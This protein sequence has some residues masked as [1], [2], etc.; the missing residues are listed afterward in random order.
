MK[1]RILKLN[2]KQV[3]YLSDLICEGYANT[4]ESSTA[5]EVVAILDFLINTQSE[6]IKEPEF[7]KTFKTNETTTA[8]DDN[9]WK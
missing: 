9:D 8:K 4:G 6:E 7:L 2:S 3:D 1:E 5:S